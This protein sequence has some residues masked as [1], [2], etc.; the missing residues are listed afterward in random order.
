MRK[1]VTSS[2][3]ECV[4]VCVCVCDERSESLCTCYLVLELSGLYLIQFANV[5]FKYSLPLSNRTKFYKLH[6]ECFSNSIGP[7]QSIYLVKAY[8]IAIPCAYLE[9]L[10]WEAQQQRHLNYY[11]H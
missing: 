2:Y 8:L 11:C 6:F 1:S 7:A 4:C 5:C 10:Q 9:K 3:C